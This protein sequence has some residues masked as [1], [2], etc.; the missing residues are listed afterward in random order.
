MINYS[1]EE[2]IGL[3]AFALSKLDLLNEVA[4]S[5]KSFFEEISNEKIDVIGEY[6]N[7]HQNCFDQIDVIDHSFNLSFSKLD[8]EKIAIIKGF[9]STTPNELALPI[10]S[11]KLFAIIKAQQ[12]ILSNIS[13]LNHQIYLK[14]KNLS[15]KTKRQLMIIKQKKDITTSYPSFIPKHAGSI[16]DFREI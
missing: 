8:N 12:K 15:L 5:M 3:E 11:R 14:T 4:V 6:I 9:L 2:T 1:D 10:W 13:E 7:K 16:L